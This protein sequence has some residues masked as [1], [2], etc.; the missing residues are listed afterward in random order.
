MTKCRFWGGALLGL[1]AACAAHH[2]AS[3]QSAAPTP[4][5]SLEARAEAQKSAFLAMPEADRRAVQDALGWL[6]LYN[7]GYG[8]R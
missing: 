7:G 6:G 2:S 8:L 1:L 4:P 3:A 5:S